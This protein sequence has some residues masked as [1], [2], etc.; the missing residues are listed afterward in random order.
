MRKQVPSDKTNSVL[1]FASK[2]PN[3]RLGSIVDGL[4]VC[5][6][7]AFLTDL[8]IS[9]PRYWNTVNPNTSASLA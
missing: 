5:S 6:G 2:R 3:D 7:S 4:S 9:Y 8:L 1:D